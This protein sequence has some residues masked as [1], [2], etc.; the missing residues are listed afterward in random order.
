MT[1]V[2]LMFVGNCS[3]QTPE[4]FFLATNAKQQ[5]ITSS[6]AFV[7]TAIQSDNTTRTYELG[8][9]AYGLDEVLIACW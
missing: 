6:L 1:N 5:M 2:Q 8:S 3:G 7:Y 4:D 9:W